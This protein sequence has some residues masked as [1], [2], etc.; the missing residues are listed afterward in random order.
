MT[1]NLIKV[2][3]EI[4]KSTIQA[5]KVNNRLPYT[6]PGLVSVFV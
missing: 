3:E 4:T 6:I 2:N 1:L 5:R